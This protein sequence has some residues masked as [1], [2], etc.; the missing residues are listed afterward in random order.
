MKVPLPVLAALAL[1]STQGATAQKIVETKVWTKVHKAPTV[2]VPASYKSYSVEYD[3]GNL[4]VP[5]PEQPRLAGLEL[6]KE[7]GDLVLRIFDKNVRTSQGSL[8]Y[9]KLLGR[10]SFTYDV[11]YSAEYGYELLDRQ[12]NKVLS[13]FKRTGGKMKTKSFTTQ[14]AL[15]G[16]MQNT[17]TSELI[18][19][20]LNTAQKRVNFLLADNNWDSQVT[21]NTI[22]GEAADYQ[23][24]NKSV[25]DFSTAVQ[26]TTPEAAKITPF[27]TQ[28]EAQL[29]KVDWGSKK[30]VVNKKVANALISNLCVAY[31]MLENYQAIK[32][33]SALF[34]S[35]NT[36]FFGALPPTLDI[37]NTFSGPVYNTTTVKRDTNSDEFYVVQ[38]GAFARALADVK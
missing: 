14:L 21:L 4:V 8:N 31:L 2:A 37:D 29:A 16:Y 13:S 38:Y 27:V 32:E 33:K 12:Q 5:L 23:E 10:E 36:G 15:D 11:S 22:E 17:F 25:L 20:L 7:G 24:I 30:A 28:W 1:L 34:D 26:G 18:K 19:D 35:Q 9:S 6:K 3:F